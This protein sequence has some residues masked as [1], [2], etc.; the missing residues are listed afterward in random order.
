MHLCSNLE[1]ASEAPSSEGK[2]RA[3]TGDWV[4]RISKVQTN[5]EPSTSL[6]GEEHCR[7]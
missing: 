6:Y 7:P 3:G 5:S 4:P 1:P 2:Y